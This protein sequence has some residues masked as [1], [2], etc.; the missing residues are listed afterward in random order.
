MFL[1][2]VRSLKFWGSKKQALVVVGGVSSAG[3]SVP[4]TNRGCSLT[5]AAQGLN[6]HRPTPFPVSVQKN[7]QNATYFG[8]KCEH[9]HTHTHTKLST[10]TSTRSHDH[11]WLQRRL[12]S[13][14]GM[15]HPCRPPSVSSL[16]TC[17]CI[18]V[19]ACARVQ[20][21]RRPLKRY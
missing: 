12:Q 16:A 21:R 7:V 8:L 11:T 19:C 13:L 15:R 4:T 2:D 6:P 3:Q 20:M 18:C 1:W 17:T 14:R 10:E 9:T 5:A